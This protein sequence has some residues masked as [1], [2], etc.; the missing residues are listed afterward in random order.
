MQTETMVL[1]NDGVEDAVISLGY[2]RSCG[3]TRGS[4]GENPDFTGWMQGCKALGKAPV[5]QV[6]H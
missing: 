6:Q 4:T 5:K 3:L 2:L 1:C